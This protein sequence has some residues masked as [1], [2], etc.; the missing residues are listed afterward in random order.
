V[1]R[2]VEDFPEPHVVHWKAC[3]A[4]L[5]IGVRSGTDGAG[6]GELVILDVDDA[7]LARTI[8]LEGLTQGRCKSIWRVGEGPDGTLCVVV[9]GHPDFDDV[10]IPQEPLEVMMVRLRSLEDAAPGL[11]VVYSGPS[12]DNWDKDLE[13]YR[14]DEGAL[15]FVVWVMEREDFPVD[16]EG[17]ADFEAYLADVSA[18][19][20]TLVIADASTGEVLRRL[21]GVEEG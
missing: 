12:D 18:P 17:E 19:N 1:V 13:W 4:W 21:A 5:L 15:R 2:T 20:G 6:S 16:G 14:T 9:A 3:D 11:Q 8:L 10:W 7:G